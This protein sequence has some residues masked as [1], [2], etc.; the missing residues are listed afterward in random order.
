MNMP[1][2]MRL[3]LFMTG[4]ILAFAVSGPESKANGSSRLE[5]EYGIYSSGSR[6]GTEKYVMVISGDTI[7]SS[8]TA[9][10]R[11][12]GSGDQRVTLETKMETNGQGT[13]HSYELRSEI[14]GQKGTIRGTFAPNQ[15]IFDYSGGGVSF[16]SGLLVGERYTILDTNVFHQFIFLARMY[17]Y[18]D[19]GR[20]QAFEVVIPQE[21]DTGT[22]RIREIGKEK[23]TAGDRQINVTKLLVDSG[24]LQIYLWVDNQHIPRKISVPDKGIEVIHGN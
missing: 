8:S 2:G 22:L 12:P 16:R 9:D 23:L 6:I 19:G 15:V 14:D 20:P 11:N 13:P 24:S 10:F 4:A 18:S 21:K 5:G 17:D 7:S 3:F 1:A